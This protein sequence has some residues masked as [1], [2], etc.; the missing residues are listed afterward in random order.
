[1]NS[2]KKL[3]K[4]S[5]RETAAEENARLEY[6]S[7]YDDDAGPTEEE[8]KQMELE[9]KEAADYRKKILLR[10]RMLRLIAATAAI[11]LIAIV[12]YSLHH[13]EDKAKIASAAIAG[14]SASVTLTPKLPSANSSV[15]AASHVLI[16]DASESA[17][18]VASSSASTLSSADIL[19]GI[20]HGDY[21]IYDPNASYQKVNETVTSSGDSV[22]LRTVPSTENDS[23]V[24]ANIQKGQVLTRTGIG[25]NG[26]SRLS[27][28]GETV[29]AVTGLLSIYEDTASAAA[30]QAASEATSETANAESSEIVTVS[31]EKPPTSSTKEASAIRAVPKKDSSQNTSKEYTIQTGSDSKSS[32]IW[33]K[34]KKIGT[35]HITNENGATE[36][37][38]IYDSY[39]Y[40]KKG[41]KYLNIYIKDNTSVYN[42][43]ADNGYIDA[44]NEMNCSG[45]YLNKSVYTW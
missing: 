20:S 27:Y 7:L 39:Y 12:I 18:S 23:M 36:K 35:M 26:W 21:H 10:Q 22:N 4:K 32:T 1:M 11:I 28:N 6:A 9:A 38:L 24:I 3:R 31:V 29:Y 33:Q 14:T 43:N 16:S 8:K 30:P 25:K 41:H 19:S 2:I 17:P 42:I 15:T 34:G 40:D 44:M 45:I 13:N 5:N 37:M